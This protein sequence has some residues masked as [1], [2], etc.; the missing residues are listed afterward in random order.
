MTATEVKLPAQ[1][2]AQILDA[3]ARMLAIARHIELNPKPGPAPVKRERTSFAVL[4]AA[5]STALEERVCAYGAAIG[6]KVRG[7]KRLGK[8][9][10]Y[11][12]LVVAFDML[13]RQG[14]VL[15][16]NKSLSKKAFQFGL[17]DV[18]RLHGCTNQKDKLLVSNGGARKAVAVRM[19][20]IFS[21]IADAVEKK[22]PPQR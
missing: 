17:G 4:T 13:R 5:D 11:A 16:R 18:L 19:D 8:K 22:T 20:R 12:D 9:A 21:R 1:L 14:I 3:K 15:P 6:P 2:D 10:L 7:N